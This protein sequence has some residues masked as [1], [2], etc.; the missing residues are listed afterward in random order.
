MIW[1]IIKKSAIDIWDEMLFL[2][3]FNVIWFLGAILIIPAP[4]VTFALFFL[5]RD[6]GE[7]RGI[8]FSTFFLYGWQNLKPAYI[9]G[10]LNLVVLVAIWFNISFYAGIEASWAVVVR[11]FIASLAISWAVLQL[12]ALALY[13]RLVEPSFKLALRNGAVIV[14]RHPL[15]IIILV[16]IA[17]IL[18]IISVFFQALGVLVTFSVIAVLT[19]NVVEAIVSRELDR[20][21]AE[22]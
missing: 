22:E 8:H 17:L 9:W 6:V 11:L 19:N 21:A 16:A 3:V 18:L 10:G 4:F 14:G 1:N 13:P 5:V 2:I 12:V 20:K 15:P 7:G